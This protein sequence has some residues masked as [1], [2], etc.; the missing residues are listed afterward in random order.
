M[1]AVLSTLCV[2][3]VKPA[4]P[5]R[6]LCGCSV[7]EVALCRSFRYAPKIPGPHNLL[8]SFSCY[9]S[10]HFAA[11]GPP[12]SLPSAESLDAAAEPSG[13]FNESA[14]L[15]PLPASPCSVE[16][17][18][19][20]VQVKPPTLV[21][22]F[23]RFCSRSSALACTFSSGVRFL[24]RCTP[25]LKRTLHN[26]HQFHS[27]LLVAAAVYALPSHSSAEQSLSSSVQIQ[28]PETET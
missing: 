14:L 26:E 2:A 6:H 24:L 21:W 25:P 22:K 17:S 8:S 4:S 13:T 5:F 11:A 20:A 16:V 7:V 3:K 1:H 18:K 19:S 23:V 10:R 28:K 27:E 15:Q 12:H 9:I